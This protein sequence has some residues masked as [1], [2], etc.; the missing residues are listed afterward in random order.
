MTSHDDDH[1]DDKDHDDDDD[2]DHDDDDDDHDDHDDSGFCLRPLTCA[3]VCMG[4]LAGWVPKQSAQSNGKQT[5]QGR[6]CVVLAQRRVSHP[7]PRREF[8]SGGRWQQRNGYKQDS[9]QLHPPCR[10]WGWAVGGAI[11]FL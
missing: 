7:Q 8:Y 2:D 10:G 6:A 11:R 3:P 1:D 4:N 9:S 5:R